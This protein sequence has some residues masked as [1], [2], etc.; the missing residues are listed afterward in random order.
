MTE[1]DLRWGQDDPAPYLV[2]VPRV[3]V[4]GEVFIGPDD[5]PPVRVTSVTFIYEQGFYYPPSNIR[6]ETE[7][8]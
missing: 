2:Q 6:V 8:V 4:V 3:P 7:R 5:M 1:I